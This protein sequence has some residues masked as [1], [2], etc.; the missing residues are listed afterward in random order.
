VPYLIEGIAYFGVLTLLMKYLSEN[1]V[2]GDIRAG[3]VVSFFTGGITFAMFFLGEMGDRYGLRRVLLI[4]IALMGLGRIFITV[5]G[6]APGGGLVSPAFLLT[7]LSLLIV[8]V[9]WGMFS[10]RCSRQ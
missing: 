3:I 9:A 8:V 1:L 4:S 2:L 7:A 6:Y 5:A 10:R